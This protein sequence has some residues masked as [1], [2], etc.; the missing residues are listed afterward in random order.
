MKKIRDRL[1]KAQQA[2][3]LPAEFRYDVEAALHGPPVGKPVSLQI[4]GPEFAQLKEIAALYMKELEG[5][6]GVY[7]VSLDLEEGKEEFRFYVKDDVAAKAGLSV[8][9]VAESIRTAFNGEVASSI[10][11]GEDRI[12]IVVRFPDEAR[13]KIESLKKVKVEQSG[14]PCAS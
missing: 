9:D 10:S 11:K 12:N 13:H 7:D 4:R 14:T 8:N 2:G 3:E 6:P 5:M 1:K